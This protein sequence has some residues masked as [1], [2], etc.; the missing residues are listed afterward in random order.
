MTHT[1]EIS[2]KVPSLRVR[3]EGQE[4]P[5]TIVNSDV[6]F[7]KHV[8]VDAVPKP[9]ELMT[10]T[11]GSGGSFE[12]EVV[13]SI[14]HDEKNMFVTACRYS[15]RSIAEADYRAL[16]SAPDWQMRALV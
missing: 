9:G 4:A 14:W 15:K 7:A 6:R 11:V 10:M 8:Q 3:K 5:E 16:M 1:I 12:C 13:S 2:L